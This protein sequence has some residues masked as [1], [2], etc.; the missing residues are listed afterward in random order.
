M[1]AN[2]ME[3]L[4]ELLAQFKE[5]VKTETVAKDKQR[6]CRD[7]IVAALDADTAEKL[8]DSVRNRKDQL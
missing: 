4:A 1:T 5:A 2:S 7:K 6:Q 3:Y 8:F